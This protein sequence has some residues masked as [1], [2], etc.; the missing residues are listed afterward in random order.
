MADSPAKR[1]KTSP[2]TSVPVDAPA[3]PSRIPVPRQDGAKTMPGRP[4]FASPTK[5]SLAK[6]HPQLLNRPSSSGSGSGRPGSRGKDLQNVF[7]KALGETQSSV[8]GP[9]VITGEERER[10]QA[11]GATTQENELLVERETGTRR[12][13]T[14][15]ARNA[16]SVGGG[17][18]AKPRRMSRSPMK[19]PAKVADE[20]SNGNLAQ[21]QEEIN[22][23]Q[24]RGLRRSPVSSQA[25]V[26]VQENLDP[27][28]KTGLRRSPVAPGPVVTDEERVISTQATIEVSTTPTAPLPPHTG[29]A[30]ILERD[31]SP[32][33]AKVDP[34][35]I[36]RPQH[37]I[38]EPTSKGPRE[39]EAVT[40]PEHPLMHHRPSPGE[41]T[42]SNRR[43]E[44]ELPPTPTQL[45]ISDP[46]VTTPPTGIH[47]T[48]SKRARRS[49][50]LAKKLKSSPL[51]PR[52]PPSEEPAKES[53]RE[54]ARE[55]T[56]EAAE[57]VPQL[58]PESEKVPKRRKSTRFLIPEDPHASKKK[59]RDNL[60][61]EL[62]QL[63]ADV[64]LANAENERLRQRFESKKPGLGQPARS[65]E[66][67]AML[68]RATASEAPPKPKPTSIFKSISSFLP[69]QPR[70][71]QQG[72]VPVSEKPIPS[73]LPIALDDPLPY[74]QAFSPLTF[75]S[76][77]TI[78][79][80]D[81]ISSS[82]STQGPEPPIRQRH[83]IHASHP[84]GLFATR[85]SMTVDT[86]NL[87]ITSLDIL[88]LDMNAETEL[89]TFIRER[90][91]KDGP[92]G[93]DVTTIC[94]AM[95]RWTEVS[96]QRA[97]FWCAIEGEFG[98]AQARANSLSRHRKRKRK[99]HA[100]VADNEEEANTEED[101]AEEAAMQQKWTRKQLLP[102]IGRTS[103][104]FT[105]DEVELRF[106]WKIRFD[107]TGEVDSH[108][109]AVAK[110]PRNWQET[111]ERGSLA[112]V[113][114]MFN[115]LVK[116]RGPLGAVRTTIGLL[117]PTS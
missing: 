79:P 65:N 109:A 63:Q 54:S 39:E 84:S 93:K 25:E 34:E 115:K 21:D 112:K 78:L 107:W 117:M 80:S 7:A 17:L 13:T 106:E 102:Q 72:S 92:L 29:I 41:V 37:P 50:A 105:N 110:L 91:R 22:P 6:H 33:P 52:D 62:Q 70:R 89:G 67:A 5:A 8:G 57:V 35:I 15:N 31:L 47:D 4:S 28:R 10:S 26:P 20:S 75:T 30:E 87:S 114:D 9:S 58:K 101:E 19:Q 86:S 61:K 66:L 1:R 77:I 85:F 48:P 49:K 56:K 12:A 90:A 36:L 100:S 82:S 108:I 45:G 81:S 116:E 44:P 113:P 68:Q 2:T 60:L 111:D 88:R 18:S 76:T 71:R 32:E 23:F 83:V 14:P 55:P 96:I 40:A 94:W 59:I 99:R 74:L 64:A 69:F 98:T 103:M 27:F 43:E 16:R 3:T 73:H 104:E 24:K 53:T 38:P 46:V 42:R 97:R 95:G 11:E 51:K